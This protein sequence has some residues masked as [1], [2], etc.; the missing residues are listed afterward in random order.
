MRILAA[1]VATTDS[2]SSIQHEKTLG[3]ENEEI[4]MAA[5]ANNGILATFAGRL[6]TPGVS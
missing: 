5:D 1:G 2:Y 4:A 3:P 6:T